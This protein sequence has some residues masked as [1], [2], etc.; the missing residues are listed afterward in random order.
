LI[1]WRISRKLPE[2]AGRVG[3]RRHGR[4]ESGAGGVGRDLDGSGL[5]D[6][7]ARVQFEVLFGTAGA[8]AL[9]GIFVAKAGQLVA[10][11]NAIAITGF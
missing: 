2:A 11:A 7:D 10:A 5:R 8:V 4:A 9:A 6:A 3:G 1:A